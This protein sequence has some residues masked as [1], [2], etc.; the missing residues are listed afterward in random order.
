MPQKAKF[1]IFHLQEG[2]GDLFSTETLNGSSLSK[3]F[4]ISAFF[5]KKK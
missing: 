5:G 2:G 1:W 3:S 4:H